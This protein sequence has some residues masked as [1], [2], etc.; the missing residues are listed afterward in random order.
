MTNKLATKP[1]YK[2]GLN[3]P[4]LDQNIALQ[5]YMQELLNEVTWSVTEKI[6]EPVIT[7]VSEGQVH[8]L[9][10]DSEPKPAETSHE[11]QLVA[12]A[13]LQTLADLEAELVPVLDQPYVEAD[14]VEIQ[15][16]S[17]EVAADDGIETK[18]PAWAGHSFRAL[19][20]KHGDLKLVMP[21]VHVQTVLKAKALV[22]VKGPLPAFMG[23]VQHG[24]QRIPVLDLNAL[25]GTLEK[26]EADDISTT[27]KGY[28]AI[29]EDHVVGLYF[30]EINDTHEVDSNA[31]S[32]R[33]NDDSVIWIAG[34]DSENLSIIVDFNRLCELL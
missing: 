34:V 16:E 15:E 7:D 8:Q 10:T 1:D 2:P 3:K 6:E 28:I 29:A 11:D 33:C 30:T 24:A 21:L 18:V 17:Y 27:G 31:I 22:P 5:S 20:A 13:K 9:T 14:E 19:Y 4:L 26:S 12:G 25:N 32:W 23:Y